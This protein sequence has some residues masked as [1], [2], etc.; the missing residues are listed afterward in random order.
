[1]ETKKLYINVLG[2]SFSIS[3]DENI[4]YLE[5]LLERYKVILENTGKATGISASEPLKLAILTGFLLCDE[6]EKM[7]TQINQNGQESQEGREAEQL[8]LELI[9]RIGQF[10][11]HE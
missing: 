4:E 8:T 3:A 11:P 10:I 1:M 6:I 5:S 9:S 7:K 2:S